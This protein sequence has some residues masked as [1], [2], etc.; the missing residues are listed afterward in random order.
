MSNFDAVDN[1]SLPSSPLHQ[2]LQSIPGKQ[3]Q[4]ANT[5]T[6]TSSSLS[7]SEIVQLEDGGATLDFLFL[8]TAI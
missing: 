2:A 3:P 4:S 8:D 5:A 6:Q 7:G 1:L